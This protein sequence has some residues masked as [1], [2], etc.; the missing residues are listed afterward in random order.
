[1]PTLDVSVRAATEADLPALHELIERSCR[2]LQADDYTPAQLDGA[3]GHALGV[4]TQLIHDRTYFVA[5]LDGKIVASGGWSYRKTLFGSD[6]GPNRIP[7][8]LDPKTDAAKIRAIFAHP[9]YARRGLGS[10]ILKHCEDAAADAGFTRL[11]MGSTLTGAPVYRLRGYVDH[12]RVDVPL[13]NG[14]VLPVIR[15]TKTL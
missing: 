4:D 5:E 12:E 14:E 10:L 3:L 2:E 8:A 1:M 9:E 15:M 7:E 11:E 6:G 13:P